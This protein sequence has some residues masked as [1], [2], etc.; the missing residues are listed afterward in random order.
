MKQQPRFRSPSLF[1]GPMAA[2][3][4]AMGCASTKPVS[5]PVSAA[6]STPNAGVADPT[7]NY[8]QASE[9]HVEPRHCDTSTFPDKSKF[10]DATTACNG[11]VGGQSFCANVQTN[12]NHRTVQQD[13]RICYDRNFNSTIGTQN[14]ADQTWGRVVINQSTGVV[15][16]QFPE[17]GAG[18]Q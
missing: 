18:C 9:A 2:I 1:L 4:F 13:G 10:N 7:C 16:S 12:H 17:S 3:A 5:P 15:V 8:T 6:S 11:L 14:G